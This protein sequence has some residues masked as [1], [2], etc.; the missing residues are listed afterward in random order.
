MEQAIYEL[1]TNTVLVNN[2]LIPL[3][4]SP[5]EVAGSSASQEIT[6]FFCWTRS[7]FPRLEELA[8]TRIQTRFTQ[9]ARI[10]PYPKPDAPNL[11]LPFP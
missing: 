7:F 11:H 4:K 6:Y 5:L 8:L 3:K 2:S 1:N 9:S 10:G